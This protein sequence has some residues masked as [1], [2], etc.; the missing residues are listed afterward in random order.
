MPLRAPNRLL[1]LAKKLL[2]LAGEER[3]QVKFCEP[4]KISPELLAV[5]HKG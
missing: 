3:P 4:P 1:Q 5:S 2:V